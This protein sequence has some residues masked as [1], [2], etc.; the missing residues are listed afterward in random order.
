[1]QPSG[2]IA[3]LDEA[4]LT[5]ATAEAIP[6]YTA[7]IDDVRSVAGE[8]AFAGFAKNSASL[9]QAVRTMPGQIC[10]GLN[11]RV[12]EPYQ[13]IEIARR[14]AQR[15]SAPPIPEP[16]AAKAAEFRRTG[17]VSMNGLLTAAEVKELGD[18]LDARPRTEIAGPTAHNHPSDIVAAPH[19]M[20]LATHPQI[21]AIA[22]DHLGVAPTIVEMNAWWT[23]P[24]PGDD[25]GAHIF[26]RDRD[27]F[28]ACKLFLYLTDVSS[29]D[30]P[31]I[32]A[33]NTHDPEFIKAMLAQRGVK[34]EILPQFFSGDMRHAA[35]EVSQIF[36]EQISEFVGPAGTCFLENTYG[37]HRGKNP[38]GKRRGLF[39][40]LYGLTPFP[41]RLN[42]MAQVKLDKL[43]ADC[44]DTPEARYAARLLFDAPQ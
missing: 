10:W 20:K 2:Q 1:M 17:V 37:F 27:D 15:T 21:L 25:Y 35:K 32:F 19:A 6:A 3:K 4:K 13:R 31:H 30:G 42:R 33:R 18:F 44:A 43:P 8:A 34:Q 40:V 24:G 14:I 28:R 38:T 39:Q 11:K 9:E 23:S 22:R 41:E 36:A 7:L 16:D 26:H 29:E 5:R 12:E